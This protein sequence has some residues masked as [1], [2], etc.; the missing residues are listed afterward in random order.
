LA[1]CDAGSG[2]G[3]HYSDANSNARCDADTN[4]RAQPETG[5][6]KAARECEQEKRI[7]GWFRVKEGRSHIEETVLG[8]LLE[9]F[10]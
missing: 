9:Q 4:T 8:Q 6:S 3:N 7:E 1:D 5:T 10:S 2:A